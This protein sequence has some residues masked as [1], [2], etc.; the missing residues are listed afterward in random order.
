MLSLFIN[1]IAAEKKNSTNKVDKEKEADAEAYGEA[2]AIRSC[3]IHLNQPWNA[4]GKRNEKPSPGD[5]RK[6]TENES[7]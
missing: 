4:P 1:R 2:G 3:I 5:C 6:N 7:N